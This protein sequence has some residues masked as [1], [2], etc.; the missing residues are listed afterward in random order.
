ML[1]LRIRSVLA[2]FR[3]RYFVLE[4]GAF[5]RLAAQLL[6]KLPVNLPHKISPDSHVA[7]LRAKTIILQ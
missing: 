7:H 4:A 6:D 2:E 5:E 1:R 3:V